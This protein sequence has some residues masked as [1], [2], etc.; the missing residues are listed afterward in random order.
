MGTTFIFAMQVVEGIA[1]GYPLFKTTIEI[2]NIV[3][4]QPV[5]ATYDYS[6]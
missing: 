4:I 3:R 6:E 2:N 1:F 5:N